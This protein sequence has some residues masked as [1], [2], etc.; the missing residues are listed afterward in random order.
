MHPPKTS[1]NIPN[2]LSAA[3]LAL[4]PIFAFLLLDGRIGSA[5]VVF[6]AAGITDAI[7]GWIARAWDMRTPLGAYLDPLADKLLT[8][9]AL[10]LLTYLSIIPLWLCVVYILKDTITVASIVLLK[11]AGRFVEIKPSVYGKLATILMVSTVGFALVFTRHTGSMF[12]LVLAVVSAVVVV[13]A[14]LDYAWREY[15]VQSGTK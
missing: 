15:R 6:I 2:A 1:F 14:G 5:A 4:V 9:T 10:V 3:R 12:F 8:A 11:R 7:D 13:V